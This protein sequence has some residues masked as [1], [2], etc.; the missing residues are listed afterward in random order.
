M[1][2]K[3]IRKI[4]EKKNFLLI[5]DYNKKTISLIFFILINKNNTFDY[6]KFSININSD[7]LN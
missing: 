3:K 2:L 6:I 7:N 5:I 4:E 1:K